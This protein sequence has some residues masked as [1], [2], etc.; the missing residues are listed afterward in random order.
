M[1][2]LPLLP[3]RT[4]ILFVGDNVGHLKDISF[5]LQRAWCSILWEIKGLDGI[6]TAQLENPDLIICE[7][8]LPDISGL[9]VCRRVRSDS[10]SREIPVIVTG[11]SEGGNADLDALESGADEYFT[12]PAD[13]ECLLSKVFWLVEGGHSK[14]NTAGYYD[15]LRSHRTHITRIMKETSHLLQNFCPDSRQ[16]GLGRRRVTDFDPNIF[17][18]IDL[19]MHLIGVTADL[20]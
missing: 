6:R 4:N 3:A 5:E 17:G 11:A 16:V 1:Y 19:G 20:F 15:N 13:S 14:P 2:D 7:K 10:N 9:D 8:K 18:G 12:L